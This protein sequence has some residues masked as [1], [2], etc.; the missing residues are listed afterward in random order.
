MGRC[1]PIRDG[2]ASTTSSAR[3]VCT[4]TSLLRTM[5]FLKIVLRM[6]LR[7]ISALPIRMTMRIIIRIRIIRLHLPHPRRHLLPLQILLRRPFLSLLPEW[8]PSLPSR[9]MT[10]TAV[11]L[12]PIR[13]ALLSITLIQDQRLLAM[14]IRVRRLLAMLIR[15]QCPLTIRIRVQRLPITLIRDPHPPTTLILDPHP[16]TT[17]PTQAMTTGRMR[18]RNP[19]PFPRHLTRMRITRTAT[20]RTPSRSSNASSARRISAKPPARGG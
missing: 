16:L 20:S 4:A 10:C 1:C 19:P 7:I 9:E 6:L 12:P 11:I 14:L 18:G 15:V 13:R 3:R 5:T 2:V 17:P 8:L